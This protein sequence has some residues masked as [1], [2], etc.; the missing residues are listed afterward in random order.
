MIYDVA[1]VGAG[2]AGLTAGIYACNAGLSVICFEKLVVGGQASLT[3][4]IVNYTGFEKITGVDLAEKML[5]HAESAGVKIE[6]QKVD[7][8]KKLKNDFRINTKL[9]SFK[10]KKIIIASGNKIRKLGLESE[11]RYVGRGVSYC[12]S[13]D[14]AF[15]KNK[16]VAVVGGGNSAYEY[17]KYLSRIVKNVYVL[18]RSGIFK[19]GEHKLNKM[20]QIKNVTILTNAEIKKINGADFVES[21]DILVGNK[22]QNIKI[23]GLFVAIGHEPDLDFLDFGIKLDKHGFI[24]VNDEQK[25][26][27]EN[28]FACGDIV[29]KKLKQIITACGDGARAGNACIGE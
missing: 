6:Y 2:P 21:A 26:S 12:A 16:T 19:M 13:C 23:D 20:K 27:V 15:Y 28:V 29:S 24:K 1:I 3:Y 8:I 5:K 22:K 9:G 4:E 7:K 10:A 11:A 14:G 18:N 17:V 25:T